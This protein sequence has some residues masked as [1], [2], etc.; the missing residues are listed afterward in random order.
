MIIIRGVANNINAGLFL[1]NFSDYIDPK[2][3]MEK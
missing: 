3:I 2:Q 1:C